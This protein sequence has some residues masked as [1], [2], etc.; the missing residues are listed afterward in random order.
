VTG[1]GFRT[2]AS[3][4]ASAIGR[5]IGGPSARFARRD[6]G[7]RVAATAII[8]FALPYLAGTELVSHLERFG[9]RVRSRS[10]GLATLAREANVVIVPEASTL[11]PTLVR[12][13]LRTARVDPSE[14]VRLVEEQLPASGHAA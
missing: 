14:F 3:Q 4:G 10:A 1:V 7:T 8:M 2:V 12:A 6:D 5:G 11:S 9:Y 13:M